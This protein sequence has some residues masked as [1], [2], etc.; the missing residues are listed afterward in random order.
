ML[1][2]R[3]SYIF[4]LYLPE[5]ACVPLIRTGLRKSQSR[6]FF[7]GLCV[8]CFAEDDATERVE[9]KIADSLFE[10]ANARAALDGARISYTNES[11]PDGRR[12]IALGEGP[13][14]DAA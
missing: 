12:W 3:P 1:C 2:R 8:K 6:M 4:A 11:Q 9:E 5:G 14:G 13:G 10:E 7:Y